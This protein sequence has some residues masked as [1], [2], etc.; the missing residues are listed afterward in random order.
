MQRHSLS[1]DMWLDIRWAAIG[2][3]IT[4]YALASSCAVAG[5]DNRQNTVLR[6]HSVHRK[7]KGAEQCWE[8]FC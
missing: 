2:S 4:T 1:H 7:T 3:A 6:D 8:S 5:W